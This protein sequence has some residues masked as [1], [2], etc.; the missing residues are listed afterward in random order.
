M[1]Q[2]VHGQWTNI[3][4]Y[5]Y[6]IR[7]PLKDLV[8]QLLPRMP[9]ELFWVS[10]LIFWPLLFLGIF[11]CLRCLMLGIFFG[12]V[13]PRSEFHN[14]V[15]IFRK[16]WVHLTALQNLRALSFMFTILPG[17]ADHCL[18]DSAGR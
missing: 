17:P 13:P 3:V 2:I 18:A 7:P 6:E 15:T 10:E 11:S 5:N 4:F 12:N 16:A 9:D 1:Q 14:A 8:F